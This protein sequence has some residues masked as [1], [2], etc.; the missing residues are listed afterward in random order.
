MDGRRLPDIS[1]SLEWDL[2]DRAS[3]DAVENGDGT[4]TPIPPKTWIID[5]SHTVMIG[6]KST[7]SLAHW[8][9]GGWAA[10]R[11]L[12]IPSSLTEFTANVQTENIRLRLGVLNLCTF[13][14]HQTTWM[15]YLKIPRWIKQATVEV[16]RYDGA[17]VD[18]TTSE[19]GMTYTIPA[20]TSSVVLLEAKAD[21]K[22]AIVLNNSSADLFLSLGEIASPTNYSARLT[23]GGY[24]ETPFNYVGPIAGIWSEAIATATVKEFL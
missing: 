21:R 8:Y 5:G 4:Y 17:E 7:M 1:N 13:P 19:Q 2:I 20:S 6:V 10:Q 16:W 15:L 12:M 18:H 22:G 24:Y 23:P 3:Y 14:K 9:T 11:L